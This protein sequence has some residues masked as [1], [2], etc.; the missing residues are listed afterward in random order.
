MSDNFKKFLGTMGLAESLASCQAD[1]VHVIRDTETGEEFEL[2][3]REMKIFNIG[4]S[5]GVCGF[6]GQ[7]HHEDYA[8]FTATG[9]PVVWEAN[10]AI[11]YHDALWREVSN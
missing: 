2:T 11:A 4:V 7:L 9:E 1:V 3:P 10:P 6:A 5:E 8:V